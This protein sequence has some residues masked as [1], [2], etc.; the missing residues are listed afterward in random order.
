MTQSTEPQPL[1]CLIL[2]AIASTIAMTCTAATGVPPDA[3]MQVMINNVNKTTP[4]QI[5]SLTKLDTSYWLSES[6]T[7]VYKYSTTADRSNLLSIKD[8][9]TSDMING[10]CTSNDQ[11]FTWLLAGMT[12]KHIYSD[13]QNRAAFTVNV[14]IGDCIARQNQRPAT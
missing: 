14:T 5:D 10:N 12:I 13:S 9:V 3:V 4:R 2:A 6:K 8:K 7:L 1:V 11:V